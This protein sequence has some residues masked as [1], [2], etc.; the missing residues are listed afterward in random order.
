M[1]GMAAS[2]G[3]AG[4][5]HTR[6]TKSTKTAKYSVRKMRVNAVIMQMKE[7]ETK[8]TTSF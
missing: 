6:K 5:A 8:N 2:V 1:N 4:R 7:G 3:I